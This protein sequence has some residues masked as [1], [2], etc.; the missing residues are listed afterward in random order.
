MTAIEL[1]ETLWVGF[2]H[3]YSLSELADQSGLP[4]DELREWVEEGVIAPDDP[5]SEPW[6]FGADRLATLRLARRLSR[7][8]EL[9]RPGV[10]LALTLLG[11][12]HDLEAEVQ[13]LRARLPA[14][15]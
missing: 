10:A 9:D 4:E 6:L 1:T 7:D 3:S 5:A 14:C 15:R 13:A 8:F 11:R 12:I 2:Q